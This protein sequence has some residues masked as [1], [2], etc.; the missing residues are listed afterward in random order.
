MF[1]NVFAPPPVILTT[2]EC[3]QRLGVVLD[4]NKRVQYLL[5]H[6]RAPLSPND[7]KPPPRHF[8]KNGITCRP[9]RQASDHSTSSGY[10]DAG[11]QRLVICSDNL[12]GEE[13]LEDTLIHEL[14]HVYDQRYLRRMKDDT[15]ARMVC[16]EIRASLLGQCWRYSENKDRERC[17]RRDALASAL[18]HCSFDERRTKKTMAR[19]WS[20]C[21]RDHTPF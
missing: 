20:T 6:I 4:T 3:T 21:Y 18:Q 10:Y 13:D 1:E 8:L 16:T 19:L 7:R 11:Y 5:H 12:K 14:V 17:V 2:F 15:C 9:C